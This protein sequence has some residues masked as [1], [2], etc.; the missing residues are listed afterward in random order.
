MVA[1][2]PELPVAPL[3]LERLQEL[4]RERR[5]LLIQRTEVGWE[6]ANLLEDRCQDL[7]RQ[8][9]AAWEHAAKLD[10]ALQM[11]AVDQ[12]DPERQAALARTSLIYAAVDDGTYRRILE[13]PQIRWTQDDA[14]I[15]RDLLDLMIEIVR[16]DP[17][18]ALREEPHG[19]PDDESSK[20]PSP[21][22]VPQASG[23]G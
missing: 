13:T 17:S 19:V 10:A 22:G 16:T 3:D 11:H 20:V 23:V 1:Y 15:I 21:A 8:L 9:E 6:Q 4:I 18:R 5:E 14:R 2:V 7:Q 12:S